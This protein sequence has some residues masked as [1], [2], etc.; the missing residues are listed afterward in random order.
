VSYPPKFAGSTQNIEKKIGT[1][2]SIYQ[3]ENFPKKVKMSQKFV[4]PQKPGVG[5]LPNEI[6]KIYVT[7]LLF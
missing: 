6:V 5:S 2:K 7:Y 1:P 3:N 4:W